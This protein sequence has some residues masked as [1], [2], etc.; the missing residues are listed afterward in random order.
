MQRRYHGTVHRR[1]GDATGLMHR[2]NG[3]VTDENKTLSAGRLHTAVIRTKGL[4]RFLKCRAAHRVSDESVEYALH[5]IGQ[6]SVQCQL[7]FCYRV[8]KCH[9]R[10]MKRLSFDQV[11]VVSTV[12]PVSEHRMSDV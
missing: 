12:K 11:H 3:R 5:V 8:C 4:F 6:R 10:G 2:Q 9:G 7:F 1:N